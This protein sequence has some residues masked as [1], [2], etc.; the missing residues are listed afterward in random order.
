MITPNAVPGRL[1]TISREEAMALFAASPIGAR[2]I[3]HCED[4]EALWLVLSPALRLAVA[5]EQAGLVGRKPLTIH[6]VA[7]TIDSLL[8]QG[9]WLQFARVFLQTAQQ[10]AINFRSSAEVRLMGTAESTSSYSE[11]LHDLAPVRF[12]NVSIDDLFEPL[13]SKTDLVLV[14]C[15]TPLFSDQWAEV[16]SLAPAAATVL[17]YPSNATVALTAAALQRRGA[18]VSIVWIE[19]IETL[20]ITAGPLVSSWLLGAGLIPVRSWPSKPRD[21]QEH[22]TVCHLLKAINDSHEFARTSQTAAFW[23]GAYMPDEGIG[24]EVIFL[25]GYNFIDASSGEVFGPTGQI[26][27]APVGLL[28]NHPGPPTVHTSRP[29]IEEMIW[30]I[31]TAPLLAATRE[32]VLDAERAFVERRARLLQ[33]IGVTLPEP[34]TRI[35]GGIFRF[36]DLEDRDALMR[37]VFHGADPNQRGPDRTTPLIYAVRHRCVDMI[38]PLMSLGADP[39]LRDGAGWSAIEYAAM[40]GDSAILKILTRGDGEVVFEV[41]PNGRVTSAV[42]LLLLALNAEYAFEHRGKG[43][44]EFPNSELIV[45]ALKSGDPQTIE[46]ILSQFSGDA[47]SNIRG[48]LD[49]PFAEFA[50]TQEA[51]DAVHPDAAADALPMKPH[52]REERQAALDGD[53]G[54]TATLTT[55]PSSLDTAASDHKRTGTLDVVSSVSGRLR[56]NDAASTPESLVEAAKAVVHA[57]LRDDKGVA[58]PD[59]VPDEYQLDWP[60]GSIITDASD[61]IWTLRFDD[62]DQSMPGRIWRTEVV[63]ARHEEHALCSVRLVRI[64]PPGQD[65]AFESV[66][67]PRV[68]GRLAAAIGLEDAGLPL[69]PGFWHCASIE[70]VQALVALLRNPA[71]AQPVLVVTTPD[72]AWMGDAGDSRSLAGRLSGAVHLVMLDPGMAFALTREIGRELAV[73]GDAA[74]IYRPGFTTDDDGSANPVIVRRP[75]APPRG[76]IARL[77]QQAAKISASHASDD[78]V[79]TFALARTLIAQS[80]RQ[81]RAVF[82][83]PMDTTVDAG[84]LRGTTTALR[85]IEEK[86]VAAQEERA[87]W[88]QRLY[89]YEAVSKSRL[90][91]LASVREGLLEELERL[92]R[93]NWHLRSV[94]E[95]L[96]Q[97]LVDRQGQ[98][99]HAVPIPESLDEIEAWAASYLGED[100]IITGKAVRAAKKS[101][102]DNPKL[103]Y[104]TLL[105]LRDHY[106]PMRIDRTDD[107]VAAYQARCLELGVEISGTGRAVDDHRYKD[108]YRARWRNQTYKLDLHVSGSSSRDT[109]RALRV[110]FAWDEV[111]GAVVVGHLPTHLTSSLTA[112]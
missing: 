92:R 30:A 10:L 83:L 84:G 57:W 97:D 79:P 27:S 82:A 81:A 38:D 20:Q 110:Y 41:R 78:D 9:R 26:V 16:E 55:K 2:I 104:E 48:G 22:A 33:E 42:V 21:E 5:I 4:V 54:E 12:R 94:N 65:R 25:D 75:D 87:A 91:E 88:E 101:D 35:T 107:N 69:R 6:Y 80:R 105:M 58:L 36:V 61:T 89:D 95:Q 70:S 40:A 66:S 111:A 53:S 56:P 74:R 109:T 76:V 108:A 43:P 13:P 8:D 64:S 73:F 37:A 7:S 46:A 39:S 49:R 60:A 112:R 24:Q 31:T 77:V 98:T 50:N 15:A 23:P 14:Q 102:H 11:L 1:A 86:L 85:E 29:R 62:L 68:V 96:R 45:S 67:I 3:A 93:A 63:V 100:V 18:D 71:R 90:D 99:T 32:A 51:I 17:Y 47:A 19:A 44:S 103:V 72:S 59:Q 106:V 34:P 28:L 52:S